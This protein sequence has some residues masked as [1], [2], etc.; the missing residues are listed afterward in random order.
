M[1]I[2]LWQKERID[3]LKE[4]RKNQLKCERCSFFYDKT[5]ESC[6]HC[7]GLKDYQLTLLLKKRLNERMSIGRYMLVAAVLIMLLIYFF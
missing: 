5:L 7:S 4:K 6:P 2:F 3:A 1:S